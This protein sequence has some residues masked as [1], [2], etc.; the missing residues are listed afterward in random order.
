MNSL[1]R[2][3]L[4][5]DP[6]ADSCTQAVEKFKKLRR[7]IPLLYATA[8]VNIVG[9]HITTKGNELVFLSP[10][11]LLTI[12]LFWRMLHW[13]FIE[14]DTDNFDSVVQKMEK[15]V[16]YTTFLCI[17]FAIW[18]QLLVS[19]HPD[20]LMSIVLFNI[21]AAL[22]AAYSLSSF[23]VVAMMP[24]A[25]LGLPIAGRLLF[26]NNPSVIGIGVRA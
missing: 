8:L 20:E 10:V 25:I 7:Q 4:S 13:V 16:A 18:A 9:L 19:A 17:G 26:Q 15:M 5:L 24:V 11:T 1:M 6:S 14:K 12:F 21:L 3:F 2:F 22:G 23:P